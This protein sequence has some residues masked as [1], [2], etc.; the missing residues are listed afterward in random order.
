MAY[1]KNRGLYSTPSLSLFFFWS[2]WSCSTRTFCASAPEISPFSKHLVEKKYYNKLNM[3]HSLLVMK[4]FK[5]MAKRFDIFLH[6]TRRYWIRNCWFACL[7]SGR[8]LE[9][10]RGRNSTWSGRSSFNWI[11]K[12]VKPY[13]FSWSTGIGST[14]K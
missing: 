4:K 1:V 10:V 12:W 11:A 6:M 13:C 9:S 8:N 7:W 5:K 14:S 3:N 2:R